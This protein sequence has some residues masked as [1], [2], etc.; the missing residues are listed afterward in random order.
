MEAR[1][2]GMR[3]GEILVDHQVINN[4]QLTCCLHIARE[5]GRRIGETLVDLGLASVVQVQSALEE[6]RR[7]E[8]T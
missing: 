4:A 1:L 6:Q 8:V 2:G 5:Q 7:M 3:L